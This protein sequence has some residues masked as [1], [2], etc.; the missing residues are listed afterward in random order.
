M[1]KY[2][3]FHLVSEGTYED[4]RE[5]LALD[6]CD[7]KLAAEAIVDKYP[8]AIVVYGEICK[9]IKKHTEIETPKL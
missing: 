6:A 4:K 2:I 8:D 1:A 7:N 3:V 9:V 5:Y